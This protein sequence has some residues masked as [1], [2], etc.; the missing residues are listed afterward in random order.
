MAK[1]PYVRFDLNDY[2]VPATEVQRTLSV[3]AS[4]RLV[5]ILDAQRVVA[6]HARSWDR[7]EV[8]EVK[9]HVQDLLDSKRAARAHR[10][11][12]RL[13]GAAPA[14]GDLLRQAA[15]RGE[16]LGRMA[17]ALGELLDQYGAAELQHAALEALGRGV[18]HV[19]AV[20]L[21]L[22]RRRLQRHDPPPVAV[23]LPEHIQRRDVAVRHPS[24]AVYDQLAEPDDAQS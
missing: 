2:S 3:V 9:Q 23:P 15:E 10:D 1:T 6:T 4:E 8:V 24:L 17:R 22:E 16:P 19:W 11:T 13:V 7:G 18:A 21:A 20:G 14:C 5:R 12:G